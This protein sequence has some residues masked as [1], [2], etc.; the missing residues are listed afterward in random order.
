MVSRRKV[1][2]MHKVI[3]NRNINLD[4]ESLANVEKSSYVL[5]RVNC[6]K[7]GLMDCLAWLRNRL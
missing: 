7:V 6:G 1:N 2:Q 3:S 5:G 4:Y